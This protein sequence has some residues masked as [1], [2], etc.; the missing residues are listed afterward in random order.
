MKR[1]GAM[2]TICHGKNQREVEVSVGLYPILATGEADWN[3]LARR[4]GRAICVDRQ[5]RDDQP[6]AMCGYACWRRPKTDHLKA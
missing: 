1:L 6:T 2:L 5:K 4:L 3:S